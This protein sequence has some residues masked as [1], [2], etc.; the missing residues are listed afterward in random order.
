MSFGGHVF[1]LLIKVLLLV[2]FIFCL[3]FTF[4]GSSQWWWPALALLFAFIWGMKLGW[5]CK[6]WVWENG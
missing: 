3:V 2:G 6:G 5:V 1:S 4:V